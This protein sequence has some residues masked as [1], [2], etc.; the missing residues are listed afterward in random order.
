MMADLCTA[1]IVARPIVARV[2]GVIWKRS[3]VGLRTGEDIVQIVCIENARDPLALLSKRRR[4]ID[5]VAQPCGFECVAVQF[6]Y[7]ISDPN[8]YCVVPWAV[9][10]AVAS[11]DGIRSLR[12]QVGVPSFVARADSGRQF[13]AMRVSSF[14][15]TY[16]AA[17]A[18]TLARDKETHWH[19]RVFGSILRCQE[20]V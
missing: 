10:D 12:A 1:G 17:V 5:I 14:Q 15:A 11:I 16:V 20:E 19:R 18:R 2:V 9:S 7:V 6:S 4:H 13:L 8:S 3:A